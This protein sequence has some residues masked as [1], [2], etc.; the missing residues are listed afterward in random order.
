MVPHALRTQAQ[1][2]FIYTSINLKYT[3]TEFRRKF[4]KNYYNL[5]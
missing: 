5:I 2:S 4:T 1:K 3:H